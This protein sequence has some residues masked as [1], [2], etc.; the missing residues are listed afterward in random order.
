MTQTKK[1]EIQDIMFFANGNT[2]VFD[3]EGQQMS[4][5][6]KSWLLQCLESIQKN[7]GIIG[8]V[9]VIKMPDG[10][11]AIPLRNEDGEITN[12]SF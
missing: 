1:K 4:E 8:E 3:N 12:W 7:G 5:F 10:Q 6:Q 11:T 2:A 9:C